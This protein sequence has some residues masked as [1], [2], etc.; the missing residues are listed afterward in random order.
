MMGDVELVTSQENEFKSFLKSVRFA[1]ERG[2]RDG[3]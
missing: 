1:A 2:A 3:D